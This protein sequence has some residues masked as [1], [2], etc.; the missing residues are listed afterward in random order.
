M[1]TSEMSSAS[2]LQTMLRSYMVQCVNMNSVGI[3][4][5]DVVI[6]PEVAGID[7]S[8]FSRTNEL[9]AS[10][11]EAVPEALPTIRS[12]LA[13]LDGKLFPDQ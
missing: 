1:P 4:P 6:E 11:E 8:E 7:L 5:A 9:A 2:I 3:Q 12:L 13:Q 10:G